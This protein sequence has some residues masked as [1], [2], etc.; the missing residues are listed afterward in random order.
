MYAPQP[1]GYGPPANVTSPANG[2]PT[3]PQGPPVIVNVYT[4]ISK[5]SPGRLPG[6]VL[7]VIGMSIYHA[8][9]EVLGQEYAFGMDPSQRPDP[10]IDG[11]FSCPPRKA[12]GDFNEAVKVGH[13]PPQ[14]GR[15][16]LD[17]VLYSLRP[18]WKAVTYH[19]LERN[20]CH[21]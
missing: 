10:N 14:F 8:G 9:V 5:E 11:V 15:Q 16:D 19:I 3:M 1:S 2:E 17:Q 4:L 18:M 21:F 13:L 20:C 6:E 7:D 12:V